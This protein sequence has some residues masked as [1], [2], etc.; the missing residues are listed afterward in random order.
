MKGTLAGMK[1]TYGRHIDSCFE[2]QGVWLGSK[3]VCMPDF[4]PSLT[5]LTDVHTSCI[6]Y[7][8]RLLVDTLAGV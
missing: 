1:Q 4:Y 8:L 5:L 6:Y 2:Y 7:S 3:G